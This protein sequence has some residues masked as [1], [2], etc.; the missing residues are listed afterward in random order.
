MEIPKKDLAA[1]LSLCPTEASGVTESIIKLIVDKGGKTIQGEDITFEL[2]S[3]RY[4]SYY[5]WWKSKFGKRDEQYVAGK[6]KLKSLYDFCMEG[7]YGNEYKIE[8]SSRDY[9][10]FGSKT[11]EELIDITNNFIKRYKD[12][13]ANRIHQKEI[14]TEST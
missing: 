7:W 4:K 5:L 12:G 9:Y 10:L 14:F 2:I 3:K 6:D 8:E 11:P 1:L 13:R